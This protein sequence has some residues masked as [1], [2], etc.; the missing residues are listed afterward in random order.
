MPEKKNARQRRFRDA[1]TLQKTG[2][3]LGTGDLA[4]ATDHDERD[5]EGL[6][7]A[8]HSPALEALAKGR[9]RR[10]ILMAG[11]G[12]NDNGPIGFALIVEDIRKLLQR[13]RK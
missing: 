9:V 7:V 8:Q 10:N 13:F 1:T 12:D 2:I 5:F 11:I 3:P 6:M 4:R